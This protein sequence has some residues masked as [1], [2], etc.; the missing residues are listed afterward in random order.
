MP[1]I[2]RKIVKKFQTCS[3]TLCSHNISNIHPIS[4]SS[5]NSIDDTIFEN[6]LVDVLIK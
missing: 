3:N 5:I 2:R 4:I 1:Y 6:I